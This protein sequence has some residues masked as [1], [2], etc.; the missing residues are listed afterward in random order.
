MSHDDNPRDDTLSHTISV[1]GRRQ[2]THTR[3]HHQPHLHT[4]PAHGKAH[5]TL[6]A[7]RLASTLTIICEECDALV[8]LRAARRSAKKR[9]HTHIQPSDG[10]PSCSATSTPLRWA[11]TQLAMALAIQSGQRTLVNR[12]PSAANRINLHTIPLSKARQHAAWCITCLTEKWPQLTV[13][14]PRSDESTNAEP[15]LSKYV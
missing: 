4:P 1:K 13:K 2:P 14:P 6:T 15:K 12:P 9:A 11:R 5:N 3:W 8:D 10:C 7:L